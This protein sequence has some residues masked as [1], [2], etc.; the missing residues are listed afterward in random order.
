MGSAMAQPSVR[1]PAMATKNQQEVWAHVGAARESMA[2]AAPQAAGAI[3]GSTSYAKAMQ[4]PEVEKRVASIA[5]DYSGLLRELRKTGAKG[6]VVAVNGRITWADIFAST[7]LLEKYWQ[8]LIRSYAAEAFTTAYAFSKVD[9]QLAQQY[10]DQLRG[11][12]EVIETEPGVFQRYEIVGEGY[13]VFT[14]NSLLPKEEFT[15]HVAKMSLMTVKPILNMVAP[16]A[17][18]VR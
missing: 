11:N 9:Q 16:P 14:L 3:G 1:M 12:H 17:G 15:V 5:A 8:K 7:D 4:N 6:V 2:S 18:M 10:V 13:K